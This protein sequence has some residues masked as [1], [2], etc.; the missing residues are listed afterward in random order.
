M[1]SLTTY[2]E[3]DESFIPQKHVVLNFDLPSGETVE[4]SCEV[5]WFLKPQENGKTLMMGLYA[6]DPPP[7][8][9]LWVNKFK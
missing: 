2:I 9:I 6:I 4:L 7:E 8:Y 1:T 3:T 5:R